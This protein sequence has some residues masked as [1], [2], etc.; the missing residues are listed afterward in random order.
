MAQLRFDGARA[1]KAIQALKRE[2]LF[3]DHL[4]AVGYY[5][6]SGQVPVFRALRDPAVK[7]V[8]LQCSRNF[9]KSTVVGLDMVSHAG[10]YPK[11][12]N[13]IIAPFRTQAEEIYYH[14]GLIDTII[15]AEWRLSGEDGFNK[16]QLRWTLKNGS[17]LKLDGADNEAT[18]RGYKPHRLAADELQD[19]RKST[20]QA[21]E[22]N[23]LAHL[24]TAILVGTPPDRPG[25]YT[26]QADFVKARMLENPEKYLYL[27]RTI[28]DNPRLDRDEINEL[29]KGFIERGEEAIWRREYMAEFVPGGASSVFPMFSEREHVRP[30]EWITNRIERD[31][32][33]LWYFTISDPSGSRSGHLFIAFD[34]YNSFFYILDELLETDFQKLS[35][36]QLAPRIVEKEKMHFSD[37]NEP[38]RLY[39]EAAKLFAIEMAALGL[40][41]SPTQKKQN[42]KSNNISLLR[43]MMVKNKIVI[44]DHCK[45]LIQELFEYHTEVLPSGRVRVVKIKD[46]LIDCALYAVAESGYTFNSSPV[47]LKTEE[48]RFYTPEEELYRPS[49]EEK[50]WTP[51]PEN[52]LDEDDWDISLWQ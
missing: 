9:G 28:Y 11:T 12:K 24:A 23:L 22:P 10:L 38:I 35:C 32:H 30:L 1:R 51:E 13:Y 46:D 4:K 49:P 34:K 26:E 18:V 7:R 21:M 29:R 33:K 52:K 42:E 47:N 5:P 40:A 39:D 19:W 14:S 15:P 25:L 27:K 41:Y 16:T 45:H 2:E 36:G 6:H 48:R 31:K 20:W 50:L 17:Y 44:A 8:F 43:D 37:R 3:L